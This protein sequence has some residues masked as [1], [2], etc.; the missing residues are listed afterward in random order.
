MTDYQ[1]E[2]LHFPALGAEP[3]VFTYEKEDYRTA[4]EKFTLLRIRDFTTDRKGNP[5]RGYYPYTSMLFRQLD[6]EGKEIYREELAS[7]RLEIQQFS[8]TEPVI[9]ELHEAHMEGKNWFVEHENGERF[10]YLTEAEALT[11][12]PHFPGEQWR[13]YNLDNYQPNR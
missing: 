5:D 11:H 6:E 8:K 7:N 10:F 3:E 1:F 2:V 13:I 12:P 4:G 9:E